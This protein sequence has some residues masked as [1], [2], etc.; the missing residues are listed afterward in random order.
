MKFFHLS[1]LHIG[2]QLHH[3]SLKEDQK[4][5]LEEIISYADSIHPDAVVIAGDIYDRSVPSAEA[6]KVFD[7]FLTRLSE[8]IPSIPVLIISGNHDS[9]ERVEYASHILK[10]HQIHLAGN[11]PGHVGEHIQRVTLRDAF[12]EVDF[13]L[14]PFLK[15]SYVRNIFEEE[16]PE[17]CTDAVNRLLKREEIDYKKRRNVLVSHQF[18]TGRAPELYPMT[19]D[20]ET[21]CVGGIENVDVSVVQDFDYVA[22]GHLHGPQSV[23]SPH[24]RYCGTLLK[25]SVSEC[26]HEKTLTVVTLGEKGETPLIELLPLHP[27]RDVKKKKGSLKGILEQAVKSEREDYISVTLTDELEAYK[28]KEQLEKVFDHILEVR[29]ENSRT[30]TKLLEL[31]EEVIMKDPLKTFADFYEEMQGRELEE[32]ELHIMSR[33]FEDVKEE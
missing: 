2:K 31:D 9:A 17:T 32:E 21:F 10:K 5:I 15:P 29:V 19:C 6:V 23:G 11:A 26:C 30:R 28:P 7:D 33:I 25:Y 1:D 8:R 20:S 12:G 27:L 18:Y 3:Y 24:I 16:P 22:L 14:L 4:V 13:Y